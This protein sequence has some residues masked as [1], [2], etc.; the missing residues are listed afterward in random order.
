MSLRDRLIKN[1]TIKDTSILETSKFFNKK[2]MIQ[3]SIPAINIAYS[4]TLD[5]GLTPGLTQWAGPS[6]HFKT[7][8]SLLSAK[9]YLD[10]YEDAVLLFYD[11]EFGTPKSYFGAV[12]IDESRTIHTPLVNIEEMK[13]DVMTQL[14]QVVRGDHLIIVIDSIGN[15]A[16]KK[17][18]DDAL[19]GK[20]VADMTRAKQLKSFFRMVT[21]HL[22]LK[23]IP[24][25]CVNHVYM[26]QEMFSKPIVSGGCLLAGIKLQMFDNSLK[27]IEDILIGD[28]VKTL[29]GPKV[30][31]ETWNPDTLENGTPECYE[32]EFEDGYKVICSDKHPFLVDG[33]WIEA[34][35]LT[36]LDEV[37]VC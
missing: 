33:K 2:D 21:P 3:T 24:M 34:Q 5:G 28:L 26:T 22:N 18:V 35:N 32:I 20:S 19:D 9:A 13:F 15:M 37:E 27:N 6:R 16:S 7:L 29:E 30:V 14:D 31:T 4:G 11:S 25:I 8:F 10:K 23:D 12:G 1:S 36:L 17:E